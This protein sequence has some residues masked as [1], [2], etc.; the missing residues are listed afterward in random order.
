M[1]I[2]LLADDEGEGINLLAEEPSV[3]SFED[4]SPEDQEKSMEAAKQKIATQYPNMPEWMRDAI[5]KLTPKDNPPMLGAAARGISDVTN[6]IPAAAGGALQGASIPIRGVASM[7]PGEFA[8]N[9]QNSPDLTGLFPQAQGTGQKSAQMASELLG[10]GGLFG[11]L[12]Q[13][14][15]GASQLAQVPQVL[16]NPIALAGAGA[17]GTPGGIKEKSLGAGGALALG[18][19]GKVSEKAINKLPGLVKGL[20]SE[21]TPEALVSAIQ[22]PHDRLQSTADEFYG[23]V[24]QAIKNRG[25]KIPMQDKFLNEARE[26]F[27]KDMK[28]INEL[29]QKAKE[30]DYNAIHKIQSSLYKKGTKQLAGDDLVKENEGEKIIDLRDQINDYLENKL[31]KGGNLDVAHTLKQGKKAHAE[32]MNTYYDKNLRKGIGKMVNSDL[33]LVPKNPMQLV[34]EDS[35]PMKAFLDKHPEAFKHLKE[36]NNKEKAKK[37]LHDLI[38]RGSAGTVGLAGVTYMGKT[39]HDLFK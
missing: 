27:P 17:I 20:M 33:R 3:G 8:R 18:G 35:V 38:V 30:G 29:F 7:I 11:K 36:I 34:D 10:G 39:L 14:V 4:L 21:S 23:Q 13:G 5:L 19:L 9:L 37:V 1:G 28:S 26:Y 16:Q 25:I 2:N 22:K 32:L 24:R 15:K 6:Y 12:M 31:I